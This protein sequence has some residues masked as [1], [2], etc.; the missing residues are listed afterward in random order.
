VKTV[1]SGVE[2]ALKRTGLFAF[3]PMWPERKV[4]TAEGNSSTVSSY[5]IFVEQ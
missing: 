1:S 5:S 2:E 4:I 3:P